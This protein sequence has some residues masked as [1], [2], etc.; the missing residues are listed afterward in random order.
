[1]VKIITAHSG[2]DGLIPNSLQF[3]EKASQWPVAALEIDVRWNKGQNQLILG[4]DQV[5]TEGLTLK[6]AFATFSHSD[7]KKLLNCDLKEP[8]LA[9]HVIA[10][11]G[12]YGLDK[13]LVLTGELNASEQQ[14]WPALIWRNIETL[15][16]KNSFERMLKDKHFFKKVLLEAVDEGCRWL[17][18]PFQLLHPVNLTLLKATGL[19]LSVWTAG[20]ADEVD[21]LLSCGV[22]N[23]TTT[24]AS[25]YYEFSRG[26]EKLE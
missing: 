24:A 16:P 2:S 1:M 21:A 8:N 12:A 25:A 26:M 11:A 17:N 7:D 15:A 19:K 13:R 4:H 18:L 22:N 10:L 6:E 3:L 14:L 9:E 23:V 20:D 5:F